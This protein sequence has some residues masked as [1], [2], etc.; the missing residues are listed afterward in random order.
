[1]TKIQIENRLDVSEAEVSRIK[2]R[3]LKNGESE[4]PSYEQI[5]I[6][7]GLP[8]CEEA[9]EISEF[10]ANEIVT[11][12]NAYDVKCAFGCHLSHNIRPVAKRLLQKK[13]QPAL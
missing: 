7:G 10:P 2:T 8:A 1:M 5:P 4:K 6:F 3:A 12:M 13:R 9:C 11:S